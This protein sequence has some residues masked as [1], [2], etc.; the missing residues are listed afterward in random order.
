MEWFCLLLAQDLPDITQVPSPSEGV[1]NYWPLITAIL[2]LLVAA[3]SALFTAWQKFREKKLDSAATNEQSRL[4]LEI[5]ELKHQFESRKQ[6]HEQLTTQ[7]NNLVAEGREL[8]KE[9]SDERKESV[10]KD[11][12]ISDLRTEVGILRSRV[13][14]LEAELKSVQNKIVSDHPPPA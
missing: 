5:E 10:T 11:G 13:T 4:N 12:V 9:L 6:L 14:I 3:V 1:G 8:R 7:I 2:S